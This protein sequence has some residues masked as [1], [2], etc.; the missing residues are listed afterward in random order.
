MFQFTEFPLPLPGATGYHPRRVSPF[1]YFRLMRLHTAHRNFSQCTTSFIGT[2]RL[3]IPRMLFLTFELGDPEIS[4]LVRSVA[5]VVWFFFCL[6][7]LVKLH[8]EAL[9][10]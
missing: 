3:G 8:P 7:E 1:G 2:T 6:Y 4:M 10:P 9:H 5:V